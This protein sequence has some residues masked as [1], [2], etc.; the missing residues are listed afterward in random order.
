MHKL[1]SGSP[2]SHGFVF[3]AGDHE[4]STIVCSKKY[5]FWTSQTI[6]LI[7]KSKLLPHDQMLSGTIFHTIMVGVCTYMG[8]WYRYGYI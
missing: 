5:L 3:I 6:A 7:N 2:S 8:E 1:S 4:T